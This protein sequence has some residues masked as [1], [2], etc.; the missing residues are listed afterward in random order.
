MKKYLI[1]FA[2]I[3]IVG[4]GLYFLVIR[5]N[6]ANAP[7]NQGPANVPVQN[8]NNNNPSNENQTTGQ[9]NKTES[10]IGKSIGGNDIIAY[11]YGSGEK[12]I[13]FVSG[14]H[15]GYSWNTAL[16]GYKIMDYLKAN[17]SAMPS[18]IKVTVIPVLNPDGLKRVV[19]TTGR[20]TQSDVSSSKDVQISGR[21]NGNN[22]D[23]NR[24]FDCDWKATSSWWNT[25]VS[26]GTKAFSEPESIAIRDYVKNNK[27]AAVVAWYS[28]AGGVY[29]SSCNGEVLPE[30]QAINN[31]YSKASGYSSYKDFD[32][33]E[34]SGDMSNWFA[35]NSVSAINVL[36]ST[37]QDVELEKNLA[38]IKA[39]FEY[40][41]Q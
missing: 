32:L 10:V 23:I 37:H 13:L 27:P 24:N 5:R 8:Q 16:L 36:L 29:S 21:Y 3:V 39:L 2:V 9:E 40:Y 38:G 41:S 35:K 34:V 31:A 33:Y 4:I 14:I 12:E 22:V 26:G 15:G 7:Q 30:T 20:F 17:P 25:T 6:N 19:G 11:H 1:V 28:A 18:D